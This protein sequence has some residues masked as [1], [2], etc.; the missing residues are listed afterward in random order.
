[1]A[2]SE[3]NEKERRERERGEGGKREGGV[4][5]A[6]ERHCAAVFLFH[7][8]FNFRTGESGREIAMDRASSVLDYDGMIA[9]LI[10]RGGQR[11]R[12]RGDGVGPTLSPCFC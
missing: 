1:M 9:L 4:Q 7:G 3:A 2:G 6:S 11:E 8:K 10:K 12:E 5:G